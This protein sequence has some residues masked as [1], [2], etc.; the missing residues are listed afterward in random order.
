MEEV[1]FN[2]E[3]LI[4]YQKS[5]DFID[6]VYETCEQFPRKEQYILASQFIRAANAIALNISEGA[7]SSDAQFNRYLQ[8]ALDSTRECVVCS[9][10]AYRRKYI[11][12]DQ[13]KFGRIQLAELSKMITSL[14]KHI[15][16]K[17]R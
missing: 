16:N 10:I 6:F 17:S 2:F 3:N 4:V 8:I 12:K 14:Q 1:K 9:T 13:D 5:L 11:L 15:K 7:G